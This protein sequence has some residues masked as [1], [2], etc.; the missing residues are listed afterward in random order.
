M[1]LAKINEGAMNIL[2]TVGAEYA[3]LAAS[4]NPRQSCRI[5]RGLFYLDGDP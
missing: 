2:W 3:E 1:N 5:C 4:G